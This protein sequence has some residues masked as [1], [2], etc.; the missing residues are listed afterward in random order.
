MHPALLR[1][2][3]RHRD[4]SRHADRAPAGAR[5]ERPVPR[6]ARS[7]ANVCEGG[8]SLWHEDWRHQPPPKRSRLV[9]AMKLVGWNIVSVIYGIGVLVFVAWGI[10]FAQYFGPGPFEVLAFV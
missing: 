6:Q 7:Q 4:R 9:Q 3:A 2:R 10:S 5:Q 1:R 8:M